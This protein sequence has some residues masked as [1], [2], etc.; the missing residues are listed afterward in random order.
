MASPYI[1]PIFSSKQ[2]WYRPLVA[3]VI[4]GLLIFSLFSLVRFRAYRI[5]LSLIR[6]RQFPW[7]DL[8]LA[9]LAAT[10]AVF[11]ES[12]SLGLHAHI[13]PYTVFMEELSE[14]E[15]YLAI[16]M[17]QLQIHHSTDPA[18]QRAYQKAGQQDSQG[19]REEIAVAKK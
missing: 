5:L 18:R 3:P 7:T 12:R 9:M 8:C 16:C 1:G 13:E 19:G 4:S 11:C 2:L 14:L 10:I 17:L 6:Q 15:A